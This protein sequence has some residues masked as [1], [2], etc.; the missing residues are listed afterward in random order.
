[1]PIPTAK[2]KLKNCSLRAVKFYTIRKKALKEGK[3]KQMQTSNRGSVRQK[4]GT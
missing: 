2:I 1:M 4:V 3:T